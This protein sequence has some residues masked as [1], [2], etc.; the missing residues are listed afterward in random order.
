MASAANRA[1]LQALAGPGR[2]SQA[3]PPGYVEFAGLLTFL[4]GDPARAREEAAKA[5]FWSRQP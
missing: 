1:M 3:V 2:A 4:R 5:D